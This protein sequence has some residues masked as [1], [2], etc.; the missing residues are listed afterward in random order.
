MQKKVL[1]LVKGILF[2]AMWAVSLCVSAQ[3]LTI[4]GTVTDT[5]GESL[6]GVS[7]QIQG[8]STGTVTDTDG[9]FV[10]LNVPSNATL[11]VSYVGML[12]QTIRVDGRSTIHVVLEEDSETLE[13]VVVVGY[14]T[15]RKR[16]LSGSVASFRS[17]EL[18]KGMPSNLL[19]AIQGKLA[20]VQVRSN[21]GQPGSGMRILVRGTNSFSTNTQPLYIVDGIPFEKGSTP[22]SGANENNNS[23]SNPLSMINP[24]DIESIDVL[25]DASATAIYGSR[26]ANGVV[27]ITTKKGQKGK[28]RIELSTNLG[29]SRIAKKIEMLDAYTYANYTNE[30][31]IYDGI[32]NNSPSP[33]LSYRGQ[34]S[35]S[36]DQY[37]NVITSSGIYS[38]SPEDFL[39]PGYRTD[40]YGNQQWIEGTNWMNEILQD[41]FQQEY[42]LSAS[43]AND[44]SHYAISGNYNKR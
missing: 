12:A 5:K 30:G 6:I 35:Y 26:G 41:G 8:S 37:G 2:T 42:N 39:N 20:G 21:D 4:R 3:N 28:P 40:E 7:V 31:I 13:E 1:N 43:A 27:L 14:G 9:N 16:D 33:T 29:F 22:K 15:M 36:Y 11:N 19:Q 10:L 23:S 17:D 24:S 38:P 32:Y 18:M 44:N 25:K 34:W